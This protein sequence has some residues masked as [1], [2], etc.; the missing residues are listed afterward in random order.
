[1]VSYTVCLGRST[2]WDNLSPALSCPGWIVTKCSMNLLIDTKRDCTG[3]EI[4]G[5]KSY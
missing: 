2:A 5:I 1:M 4:Q 3:V